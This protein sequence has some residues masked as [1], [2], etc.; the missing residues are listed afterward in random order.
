MAVK[1][2][3]TAVTS[4]ARQLAAEGSVD[5]EAGEGKQRDEPEQIGVE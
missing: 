3:A 5:Q 4:G 1:S 2:R